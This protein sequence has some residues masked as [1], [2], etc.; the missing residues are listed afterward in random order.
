M[1]CPSEV[2]LGDTLVF[3]ICTHDP[4][5]GVLTDA[6]ST[7]YR[8]YEDETGTAI[9]NSSLAKLDDGNTTGFYTETLTCSTANGYEAD[10][11]YTIY[12]EAT[13]DS[14]KG[15][16]AYSFKVK[17]N[18]GTLS[19]IALNLMIDRIYTRLF[20]EVNV[21]DS[22][23]AAVIRNSGDSADIATGSITDDDTTTQQAKWT[24]A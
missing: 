16:I 20:H 8:F 22:T 18:E 23:G 10:K 12:I 21:T 19:G 1:G 11:T 24:W 13:V 14:D 15:G 7:A 2:Y 6:S 17:Q 9:S 4:D 5:T 3:S